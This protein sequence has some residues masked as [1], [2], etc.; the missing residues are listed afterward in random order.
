MKENELLSSSS[1]SSKEEEEAKK[2]RFDVVFREEELELVS[3]YGN[4]SLLWRM[5]RF[6]F[7]FFVVFIDVLCW[8]CRPY[9][10]LKPVHSIHTLKSFFDLIPICQQELRLFFVYL[11]VNIHI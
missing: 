8:F 2:K 6:G 4:G 1:Y 10:L 5:F 9:W 7:L 3:Q 11:I